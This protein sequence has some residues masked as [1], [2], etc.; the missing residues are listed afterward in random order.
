[1]IAYISKCIGIEDTDSMCPYDRKLIYDKLLEIKQ[2]EK[3]NID[4]LVNN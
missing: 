1:M 2:I 4:K 3:E